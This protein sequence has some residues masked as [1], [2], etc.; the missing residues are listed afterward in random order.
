M[1]I[2]Y[3]SEYYRHRHKSRYRISVRTGYFPEPAGWCCHRHNRSRYY[4]YDISVIVVVVESCGLM[5]IQ[6]YSFLLK[7]LTDTDSIMAEK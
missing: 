1:Y 6:S 7:Q 2:P 4:L 5:R 3:G